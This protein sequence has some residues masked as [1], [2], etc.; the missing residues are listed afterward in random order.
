MIGNQLLLDE[1]DSDEEDFEMAQ[2]KLI[3][4]INQYTDDM[5]TLEQEGMVIDLGDG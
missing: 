5:D 1:L 4:S 3:E 2:T